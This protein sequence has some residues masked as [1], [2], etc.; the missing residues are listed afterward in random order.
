LFHIAAGEEMT[1]MVGANSLRWAGDMTHLRL[2]RILTNKIVYTIAALGFAFAPGLVRMAV[3]QTAATARWEAF[4][5]C[6]A[7]YQANVQNRLSDPNRTLAM[8]NM[9]EDESKEYKLSAME[10]YE[11]DK[12]ATKDE[13][14][15]NIS[16]HINANVDR[17]IAMDKAGTLD[18][19]IDMCPQR[20]EP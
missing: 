18:A 7:A 3:A 13:A 17:F 8:R 10:Y 15:R 9:I 14:D 19:Y 20:E 1:T 4:A 11:K 6:A 12:S 5:N 16:A 2:S